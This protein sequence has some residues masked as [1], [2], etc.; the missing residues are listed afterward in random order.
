MPA[1]LHLEADLSLEAPD[2]Q[3][4]RVEASGAAVVLALPGLRFA[5]LHSS[6]LR[7]R[8]TRVRLFRLLQSALGVSDVTMELRVRRRRIAALDPREDTGL[9]ARVLGLP[10]VTLFPL[11]LLRAAIGR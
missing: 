10:G 4:I 8:A 11:A 9:L 2:G 6:L 1:P 5:L 3:C 7:D